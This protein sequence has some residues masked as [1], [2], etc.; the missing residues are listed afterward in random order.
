MFNSFVW[1]THII[2]MD[3]LLPVSVRRFGVFDREDDSAN[4]FNFCIAGCLKKQH[5]SM[6]LSRFVGMLSIYKQSRVVNKFSGLFCWS[7]VRAHK[8]RSLARVIKLKCFLDHAVYS[9]QQ[10]GLNCVGPLIRRFF[11]EIYWKLL[12]KF[13]IS[14]KKNPHRRPRNISKQ[15]TKLRLSCIDIY[16]IV[17]LKFTAIKY[18]NLLPKK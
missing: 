6:L 8:C 12:W 15:K 3:D 17:Y 7:S 4:S 10:L 14:K 9:K 11:R 5:V 18:T 16:I 2:K 1:S 13:T